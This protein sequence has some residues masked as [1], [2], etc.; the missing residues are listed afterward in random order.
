MVCCNFFQY[1]FM[2]P[3]RRL[4]RITLPSISRLR[5]FTNDTLLDILFY[6]SPTYSQ[7]IAEQ[8]NSEINHLYDLFKHRN[9]GFQGQVSIV[10]HSLGEFQLCPS[11]QVIKPTPSY[12]TNNLI[13]VLRGLIL[14]SFQPFSKIFIILT[15]SLIAF[16]LLSHQGDGN[17][18]LP[19]TDSNVHTPITPDQ[20]ISLPADLTANL[21]NEDVEEEVVTLESTLAQL[22]LTDFLPKFQ[23]ERIDMDSL[24]KKKNYFMKSYGFFGLSTKTLLV[25][26]YIFPVLFPL[27]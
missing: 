22:G 1:F 13:Y 15:G 14:I 20:S 27:F 26:V 23:D 19:M 8:V 21:T 17:P 11:V 7:K 18:N 6:S 12:I 3:K 16:D 24:V 10:G 25:R 9:A 2:F 4:R 5:R